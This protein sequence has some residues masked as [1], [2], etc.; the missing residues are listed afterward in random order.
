[1]RDSRSA[2]C[3]VQAT[4]LSAVGRMLS[5]FAASSLLAAVVASVLAPLGRLAPQVT[6]LV[7]YPEPTPV[8]CVCRCEGQRREEPLAAVFVWVPYLIGFLLFVAGVVLGC[9]GRFASRGAGP[10]F[11]RAPRRGVWTQPEK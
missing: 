8:E 9:C 3:L 4:A 5:D 6:P 1:M 2:G 7:S 10:S 11:D